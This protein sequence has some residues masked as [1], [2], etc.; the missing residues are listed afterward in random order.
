MVTV[1]WSIG[2]DS[3]LRRAGP[4]R[5]RRSLYAC[6]L[7][8]AGY[9]LSDDIAPGIGSLWWISAAPVLVMIGLL[10]RGRLCRIALCAALVL[11]GAGWY[12]ARVHERPNNSIAWAVD[13]EAS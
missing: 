1:P 9:W 6:A 7:L 4:K 3:I 8:A 13:D 12:A 5:G 10:A 2:R 11:L